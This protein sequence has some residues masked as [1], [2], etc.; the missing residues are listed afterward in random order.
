MNPQ[1]PI[2]IQLKD[3]GS[4]KRPDLEINQKQIK[5]EELELHLQSLY[6]AR[7]DHVA[8]VKGDPEIEFAFVAEALDISHRAGAER[9][10]LMGKDN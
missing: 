6:R 9:V 2:V 3:L 7:E 10:G 4:G 5:W 1:T 8:F